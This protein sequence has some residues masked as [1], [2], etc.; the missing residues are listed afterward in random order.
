MKAVV[1]SEYGSPDVL[2]L[3]EVAKPIP[4]D[5][6]VMVKTRAVSING[7][8]WEALVG[9]PLYVRI[10]G[11]RRP[12]QAILGS[13][14]AGMVESVGSSV[15]EFR[16]G[17]EVFG[18]TPTYAGGFAEYVCLPESRLVRKPAG[19]TFEQVSAIPRPG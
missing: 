17:D 9:R 4:R 7:S 3:K 6:E 19:L 12:G 1:Y 14:V 5:S 10:G 16:P 13:D 18:D 8:D 2:Q 15:K 11:L